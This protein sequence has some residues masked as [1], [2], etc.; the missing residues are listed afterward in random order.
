MELLIAVINDVDRMDEILSG[1]LEIGITGATIFDSEG[2]GRVLSHDIPIF[3][4]L[5]TLISRSRPQNQTLFSVIDDPRKVDEAI[6]LL[7][8]VCGR[9]D[10]PATGIAITVPVTRVVGLASELGG[11]DI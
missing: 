8:E 6:A 1:F 4:G 10:D 11:P 3:A 5:Q 7:Q 9:F 2:M